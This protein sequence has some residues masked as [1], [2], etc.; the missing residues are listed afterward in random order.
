MY[1][2]KSK[3]ALSMLAAECLYSK[4]DSWTGGGLESQVAIAPGG[5]LAGSQNK[6]ISHELSMS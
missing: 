2:Q 6:L 1:G 5:P 3:V 4:K